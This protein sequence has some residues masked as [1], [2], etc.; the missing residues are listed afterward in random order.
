MYKLL[1]AS[2]S[3][4]VVCAGVAEAKDLHSI[5]I[6]VGSLGNPFFVTIAKGAPLIL[7][8][9]SGSRDPKRFHDPD[10]F[11]P[12]RQDNRHFGFGSGVHICFGAPL[13]R[14]EAQIARLEKERDAIHAE[15]KRIRENLGSLGDRPSEK[16]LRERFVRTL[17]TQEDRLEAIERE[18]RQRHDEREKVRVEIAAL[19]A[20]L[21][22][23]A[24]V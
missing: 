23:D 11:D 8:L 20:G 19:V 21:E 4:L 14:I 13:A 3:A 6:T 5:G 10:H 22:Y 9:A 17:N 18:L 16:D 7:V 12:T 1:L 2:A 15:Q 24:K